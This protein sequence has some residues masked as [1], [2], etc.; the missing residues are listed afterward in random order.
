LEYLGLDRRKILKWILKKW[1]E[2]VWTGF[3]WLRLRTSDDLLCTWQWAWTLHIMWGSWWLASQQGLCSVESICLTCFSSK[4]GTWSHH[5]CIKLIHA[6]T[7]CLF[8]FYLFL[9]SFFI[10]TACFKPKG[11]SAGKK[12]QTCKRMV[13]A[14]TYIHTQ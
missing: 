12:I 3:I 6:T 2:S 10:I 4:K 14:R 9:C 13:V 11:S 8:I 1:A 5:Q 7:V